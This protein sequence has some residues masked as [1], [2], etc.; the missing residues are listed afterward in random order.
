METRIVQLYLRQAKHGQNWTVVE[1][2]TLLLYIRHENGHTMYNFY[3]DIIFCS[4]DLNLNSVSFMHFDAC[5]NCVASFKS[6]NE[7][8]MELRRHEQYY[9]V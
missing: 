9:K 7:I 3:G 2:R 5:L 4:N 6:L 8:L 1:T